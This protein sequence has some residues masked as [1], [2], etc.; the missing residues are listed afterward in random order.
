MG[1]DGICCWNVGVYTIIRKQKGKLQYILPVNPINANNHKLE[2][3]SGENPTFDH[4]EVVTPT[5]VDFM[6]TLISRARQ[7]G[8]FSRAVL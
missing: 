4:P 7:C 6:L 1:M 5:N 3:T 2:V 8:Y